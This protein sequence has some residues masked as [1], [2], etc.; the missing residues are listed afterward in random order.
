MR[1]LAMATTAV[2]MILGLGAGTASADSNRGWKSRHHDHRTEQR[3]DARR[4]AR[5]T[6]IVRVGVH[7][8][9]F[10]TTI[11]LRRLLGLGRDYRGYRIQSVTVKVRPHRTRARL[12]LLAN[13]HV[14]DRARARHSR[15]IELR[16]DHDRTLGRDLGRLQLYVHGRAYIDSIQVKLRAPRHH[17]RPH[18]VHRTTHDHRVKGPDL[19]EQV[20][21]IILGQIEVADGRY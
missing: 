21:R 8:R 20:V 10:D 14:V 16:P 3:I 11:P 18:K 2:A 15:R 13:G 5:D 4:H 12:A 9:Y 6:E 1:R 19:A 17:R 7:R